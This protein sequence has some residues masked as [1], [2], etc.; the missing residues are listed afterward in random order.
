MIQF[1]YISIFDD[2]LPLCHSQVDYQFC[3]CSKNVK[4]NRQF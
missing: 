3:N 1:H 2:Y 4:S